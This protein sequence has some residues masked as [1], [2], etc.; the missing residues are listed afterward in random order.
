MTHEGSGVS[1]DNF[2]ERL[3]DAPLDDYETRSRAILGKYALIYP[4]QQLYFPMEEPSETK[5]DKRIVVD[6]ERVEQILTTLTNALEENSFPYNLDSARLA[7]DHRHLPESLEKGSREHAMFLFTSC[8]YMRGGVKSIDAIKLLGGL[9]I[10]HPELF[11]AELAKNIDPKSIEPMLK[12]SGLGYQGTVSKQ[13]VNNA[14][15]LDELWGGNPI[16][17]FDGV[18]TYDACV[19]RIANKKDNNGFWGFQEKM[20]SMITYYLMD[21]GM[22][23]YFDFPP[24]IDLHLM[25]VSIANEL[26]K[27]EGYGINDNLQSDALLATLR[28]AFYQFAIKHKV[29]VLRLADAVW[30]LSQTLCGEQ[31]GN[32]TLEPLGRKNRDG[33]NT[34]LIAQPISIHDKRQRQAYQRTCANCPIEKTCDWNVPGKYYVVQGRLFRR[35]KRIRYPTLSRQN[36]GSETFDLGDIT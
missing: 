35:G 9:Y 29:N 4:N 11:S 10:S 17:I 16:N 13:W 28:D 31:P 34:F 14:V 20:G 19:E 36:S 18:S 23:P 2:S 22:I 12:S 15:I 32:I 24:P 26:V 30:L 6:V 1:V 27:F 3:F 5:E 33:H 25:R 8:Y 21:E 7:Q